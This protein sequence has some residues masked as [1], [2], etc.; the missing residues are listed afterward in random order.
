MKRVIYLL[1]ALMVLNTVYALDECGK[2][3]EPENIPC[4]VTSLW[5]YTTPC[6]QWNGTVY[7][8][9]GQNVENYSFQSLGVTGLCYFQWNITNKGSYIYQVGNG[10]SGNITIQVENLLIGL[11]MG[12]GIVVAFLMWLAFSLDEEHTLLKYM[13]IFVGVGLLSII[14]ASFV[15][16]DT[17]VLFHKAYLYFVRAF[18]VYVFVYLSYIVLQKLGIVLPKGESK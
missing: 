10:D 4:L 9:T 12:I 16:D 13:L 3:A 15:V 6:T 2:T 14:P 17:T 1:M 18:W 5:N 11:M 8:S 7:N